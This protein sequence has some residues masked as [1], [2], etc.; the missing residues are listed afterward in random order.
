MRSFI[1]FTLC[2]LSINSIAQDLKQDT[3]NLW[4]SKAGEL[5]FISGE[6]EAGIT[7][8]YMSF[9][10]KDTNTLATPIYPNPKSIEI[11]N[12][13]YLDILTKNLSEAITKSNQKIAN[14]WDLKGKQQILINDTTD[15]IYLFNDTNSTYFSAEEGGRLIQ[16]LKKEAYRL[17]Q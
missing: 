12:G 9:N 16:A 2:I 13:E 4:K 6:A 15:F 3:V 10:F 11:F 8:K 17:E 14:S 1:L 7:Y 5:Q